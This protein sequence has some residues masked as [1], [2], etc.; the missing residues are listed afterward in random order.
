MSQ[1]KTILVLGLGNVLRSDDGVGV[2]VVW[3]LAPR[4]L[5]P[6]GGSRICLRDGGTL[7]LALL[8]EIEAVQGLIVVDAA[9][10]GG[11]P[12]EVRVFE[13][14]AMDEQLG[15]ARGSAHEVALSDLMGAARL[16]DSLPN[17]RALV[18]VAP[19]S[20]GWGLEPTPAVAASVPAACAAVEEILTRWTQ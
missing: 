2:H 18:G 20:M 17:K 11:A 12:G 7:G 15:V 10:F 5:E 16:N 14:A 3:A 1:E 6:R 8:P 19:D 13:A 4:T 9:R